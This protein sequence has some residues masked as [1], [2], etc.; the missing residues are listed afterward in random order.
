MGEVCVVGGRP[1]ETITAIENCE[2]WQEVRGGIPR[3]SG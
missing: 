2:G 1:T 3:P